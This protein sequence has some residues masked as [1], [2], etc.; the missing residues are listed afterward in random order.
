MAVSLAQRKR[1]REGAAPHGQIG[2]PSSGDSPDEDYH[3][4]VSVEASSD[5]VGQI[6]PPV[7]I[8]MK[9]ADPQARPCE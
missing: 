5:P 3:K 7:D 4:R 6:V 8:R 2:P 9:R 1:P